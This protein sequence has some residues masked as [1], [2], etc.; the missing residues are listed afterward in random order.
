MSLLIEFFRLPADSTLLL[1]TYNSSLV[2]L[3]L[4]I[5]MLSS[6][7]ALFSVELSRQN[8]LRWQQ[9]LGLIAG[10]IS[11]GIGIWSMH[12]IGMLAFQ[13][14]TP[15][16]Y[17][18]G[19]TLFSLI[20]SVLASWVA[21]NLL[22]RQQIKLIQLITG[23][24]LV[25][26]GIGA[27][28]YSG[29][30]A[31]QM[32]AQLRYDPF[33]FAL[34]ILV[35]VVMAFLALWIRFGVQSLQDRLQSWQLN[36]LSGVVMGLAISVMHYT[37]MLAARFVVPPG[38]SSTGD[39]ANSQQ[40]ALIVTSVSLVVSLLV[41]LVQAVLKFYHAKHSF[42]NSAARLSAIMN[43]ALDAILTFNHQGLVI[44]C[45]KAALTLF[46]VQTGNLTGRHFKQLLP[47]P[48]ALEYQQLLVQAEQNLKLQLSGAEHQLSIN[49]DDQQHIPVRVM[50]SRST[51][52]GLPIFVACLSDIS[53]QLDAAKTLKQSEQKFR[54]L[55]QNIPGAAYRCLPDRN[56]SM[57]FISDAVESLCG[58]PATDFL[59]P[60]PKRNWADLIL[61]EDQVLVA[62]I[63]HRQTFLLEYR[64]RHK[65]GSIRWLLEQGDALYDEQGAVQTLDGFIMDISERRL[66]EEQ[67]RQAKGKAEQAA[68][69]KSA[70]LANMSHEI[71]TPL[72]AV[73]GFTDLLLETPD[74]PD[75]I[76]YI[77][78]VNQ[79]AKSLLILLNDILDS[80]KLEKGKLELEQVNFNLTELIDNVIST[81]WVNARKKQLT[82]N[83]TLS[84]QLGTFYF[85]AAPRIRQVLLNMLGNAIKFTEQGSVTLEVA[86]Q[87]GLIQFK[88]IDTG[89][90]IASDRLASIFE[91]FTQADASM[92]RRFGGT[93][94]GTT[95]SKQ[96]VALMGGSISA[97]STLGAG[98][99]FTVLLP[100][101]AGEA[102]VSVKQL[103]KLPPLHILIADDIPQNIELLSTILQRDQHQVTTA[104][105][106]EEVLRVL[107]QINP[108]LVLLDIQMPVMDGLTATKLRREYEIKYQLP[109]MPIIAL[110]ASALT[111][112]RQAVIDAGMDGFASKPIDT[113][114]LF[115]E[116]A[117]VLS[118]DLQQPATSKAIA[119]FAIIAFDKGE[120]LWG[121]RDRHLNELQQFANGPLQH[122]CEDILTAEAAG[123][124]AALQRITHSYKGLAGNLALLALADSCNRLEQ[125]LR[126]GNTSALNEQVKQLCAAAEQTRKM[127]NTLHEPQ[128]QRKTL[129]NIAELP[130]LLK[131]LDN[132]LMRFNYDDKVVRQLST[133]CEMPIFAEQIQNIINATEAFDFEQAHGLI[134]QLLTEL[135]QHHA[136]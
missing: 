106:G 48:Y 14:C 34:S 9:Q 56:W 97:Q 112:D 87:D 13:L 101:A 73:I 8:P 36:L 103:Y 17:A 129:P 111:E 119:E 65:D 31:M 21:L 120:Q 98:S 6:S 109:R 125:T 61:P 26:A 64:I 32:A 115:A 2:A 23:G 81:L 58:Y 135:E 79:S 12:F 116:I 51:F 43:T 83:F 24:V 127:I 78:T 132:Q 80:A 82:L 94:L 75:A 3:S 110:T 40:M 68:E 37:G 128:L 53:A 63:N 7:A 133:F 22:I 77:Q 69:V 70:F 38:F 76:R 62:G 126:P 89:I 118:I 134:T 105:N 91:P 66:M 18:N 136:K 29:M 88:I 93:G 102:M 35:A 49:T 16:D 92:S 72:N 107:Q 42:E 130:E 123:D 11:L 100:L 30:A 60:N 47:E 74:S 19:T 55:M 122:L 27:M 99:T 39:N 10:S 121:S 59:L 50:L 44:D 41:L 86:P 71:R 54:S 117:R 67:L 95:I 52:N 57:L 84:P 25:G 108:D 33:F 96:L 90:G 124:V 104:T 20:P 45:N 28:H 114:M 15:V 113:D 131:Q 85:G 4:L 46:R 1:G 5:A